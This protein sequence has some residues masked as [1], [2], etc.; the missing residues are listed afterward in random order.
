MSHTFRLNGR[1]LNRGVDEVLLLK[2]LKRA[3]AGIVNKQSASK[4]YSPHANAVT[5]KTARK[6]PAAK[7]TRSKTAVDE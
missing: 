6:A 1:A 4:T 5:V 2:P 3:L 7:Y